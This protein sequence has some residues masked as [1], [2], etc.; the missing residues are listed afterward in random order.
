MDILVSAGANLGGHEYEFGY[1]ALAL[2]HALDSGDQQAA[3]IW[4]KTGMDTTTLS[5][6]T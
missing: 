1:A 6:G 4:K 5:N 2:E 3:S